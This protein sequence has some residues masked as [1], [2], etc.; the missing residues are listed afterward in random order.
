MPNCDFYATPQDQEGLLTWLFAEESCEV[1]ELY[2]DFE[3]PLKRFR[4]AAEVLAQFDRRH[5]NGRPWRSVHLNLYVQ[6]AGPV[7][8]PRRL[9][10]DPASCGGATFRYSA[11]GWGMVQLYLQA[12]LMEEARLD[13][14]HTD[15]NT[16][17]RAQTW[18]VTLP[19][20]GP[21]EAWDFRRIT[22]FSS[23]FNRE[24]RKRGV[25]KLQGR[26]LHP[27]AL[28]LWESGVAMGPFKPGLH[29][30]QPI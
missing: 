6:G 14:S 18:S 15:H 12:P 20:D 28:A 17:Q 29:A 21:V 19:E 7:F 2:S 30:L 13:D 25:A 5:P 26:V 11:S 27:R 22:S 10:L 8:E 16:L 3:Q 24:I 9:R 1:Y 4:S 23:R